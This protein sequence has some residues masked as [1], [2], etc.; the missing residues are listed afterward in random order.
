MKCI[1]QLF[2][3][4]HLPATCYVERRVGDNAIDPCLETLA[5]I[6]SFDCLPRSNESLLDRV[7]RVL[8]DRYDRSCNE[9][10]TSLMQT[11]Q[12][13]EGGLIAFASRFSQRAFLIRDTHRAG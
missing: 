5:G 4:S 3:R 6:E 7:F 12:P 13:G 9:V 10:R 11:N 8:V 1:A 2:S